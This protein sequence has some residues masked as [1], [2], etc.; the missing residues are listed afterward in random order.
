MS[1]HGA[2]RPATS[3]RAAASRAN[4]ARS[5]GPK[6]AEGKARS[7]RNAM[8]HGLCAKKHLLLHDE[9][10]A[11]LV[12]LEDALLDDLA[13]RGALQE[14][15]AS[16]IASAAW[17]MARAAWRP[18]SSTSAARAPTGPRSAQGLR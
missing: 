15:L 14:I 7:S 11:E 5:R 1:S 12:T 2:T 18:R 6:T 13:P 4:G 3:A 16:R 17:R 8:K 10:R 9:D